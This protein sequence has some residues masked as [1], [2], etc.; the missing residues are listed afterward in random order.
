MNIINYLN[1]NKK[2]D[3]KNYD[4]KIKIVASHISK[5]IYNKKLKEKDASQ[6]N[7]TDK[8]RNDYI[9]EFFDFGEEDA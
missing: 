3:I 9:F 1:F 7:K 5:C 6:K 2:E 4:E 8:D